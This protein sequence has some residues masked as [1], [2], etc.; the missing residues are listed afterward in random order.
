MIGKI[1]RL[2]LRDVWRHEARD[3]TTWL[4]NNIDV[5]NDALD[6]SL[7]SVEREQS[8]GTFS[9]D[10]VGEDES[11]H[12]VII[13]NQLEKSDHDHLGKVITY[14]TSLEARAAVWIV[15]EPRPE[16]VRAIAWLNESSSASFYLVKVEAI[17]IGDSPA[18]PLLTLITGPSVEAIEAG[19]KKKEL[20][21]RQIA[22]KKFWTG[23]LEKAKGKTKLHAAI[24]P[25]Y[26]N[27][28][29]TSA[30]LPAGVNLNYSIRQHDGQ[31]ELY[32]DQDRESGKGN[33]EIFNRLHALKREIEESFG[34]PL[35][36]EALEGK[37]ACRIQKTI[38][39]AGWRDE[40]EWT[41]AQ[42]QMIDAMIRLERALRPH[43]QGL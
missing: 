37:R 21:D 8:A 17:K 3:F 20:A 28:V 16:H 24:S 43:L 41:E 14:L 7:V 25:G 13:E 15:A 6:L 36:W 5:L 31:V 23:L 29:G 4:E 38:A 18:A 22:R 34:G 1:Q 27:W 33:L 40:E 32:I 9:I 30:G 2:P 11:G 10:L 12:I 19:E 39:V 42:D 26:Y 35:Q